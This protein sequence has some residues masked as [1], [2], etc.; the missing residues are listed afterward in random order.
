M[1]DQI[2]DSDKVHFEY[3]LCGIYT[4]PKGESDTMEVE[5]SQTIK[6]KEVNKDFLEFLTTLQQGSDS[7]TTFAW[8]RKIYV[9]KPTIDGM[10]TL[11]YI[12]L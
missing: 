5:E 6:I 2:V 12:D 11:Y 10:F 9:K 8:Q 1:D 7:S 4:F 3:S